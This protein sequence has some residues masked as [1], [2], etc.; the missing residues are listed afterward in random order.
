MTFRQ[1]DVACAVRAAGQ[2]VPPAIGRSGGVSAPGRQ[3][4]RRTVELGES[5]LAQIVFPPATAPRRLQPVRRFS[6]PKTAALL[7][8]PGRC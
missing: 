5:V 6:R 2:S 8:T 7:L 3:V 1:L 4:S